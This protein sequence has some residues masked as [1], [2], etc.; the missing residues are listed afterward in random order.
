MLTN[1]DS[2]LFTVDESAYITC[3]GDSIVIQDAGD[4]VLHFSADGSAATTGDIIRI[5]LAKNSNTPLNIGKPKDKAGANDAELTH[6]W[7]WYLNGLVAGDRL[8]F[9]VTNTVDNDDYTAQ[10]CSVYIRKEHSP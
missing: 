9:M 2:T 3:A 6:A 8:K 4:Y 10:D 7:T 5:G 1:A